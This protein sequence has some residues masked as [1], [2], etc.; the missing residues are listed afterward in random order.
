MYGIV[1]PCPKI[2]VGQ[3]GQELRKR[4]QEHLSSIS[5]EQRD[6]NLGKTLTLVA[7]HFFQTHD[8]NT[9]GLK[10]FGLKKVWPSP[11]GGEDT[12]RLLQIESEWI[13]SLGSLTPQGLNEELRYTGVYKH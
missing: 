1:C 6:H 2:Y 5:L 9:G 4:V 8:S 7:Q 12:Q 13:Y 3:T 11:R 10:V